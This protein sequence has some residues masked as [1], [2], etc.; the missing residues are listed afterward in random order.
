MEMA[1]AEQLD[2]PQPV[3]PGGIESLL[4]R[5]QELS[6]AV[7][8]VSSDDDG[9]DDSDRDFEL[10]HPGAANGAAMD[11]LAAVSAAVSAWHFDP[12]MLQL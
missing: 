7:E 11:G 5:L 8:G 3:E 12:T 10:V 4:S 1:L 6:S 9:D 2:S